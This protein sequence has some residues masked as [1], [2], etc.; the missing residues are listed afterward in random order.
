VDGQG[1]LA[2]AAFGIENG[3][4]VGHGVLEELPLIIISYTQFI[5][6]SND[7]LKLTS[8]FHFFILSFEV[9]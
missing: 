1:G 8:F 6:Y 2:G 7:F 5:I 9:F 3:D 4:N